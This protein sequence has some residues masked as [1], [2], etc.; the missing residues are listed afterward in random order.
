MVKKGFL[1]KVY[2]ILSIQLLAT[3]VVC[4]MAMKMTSS[5]LVSRTP[6]PVHVL[7]FFLRV[8]SPFTP[9]VSFTKRDLC[10]NIEFIGNVTNSCF[11]T[12]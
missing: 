9:S 11:C 2:G 8:V 6:V 10:T 1:R 12:L 5:E 4:A 3:A 7:Y